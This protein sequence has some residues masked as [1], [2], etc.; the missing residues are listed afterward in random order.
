MDAG[1]ARRLRDFEDE[2]VRF[3]RIIADLSVQK[4][5]L[6]EVH[7]KNGEPV[8]EKVD[9]R[10]ARRERR[11]R[12]GRS[13]LSPSW[14]RLLPA[15]EHP[16]TCALTTGRSS[17]PPLSKT[18]CGKVSVQAMCITA[19]SAWKNGYIESFHNNL[20]DEYLN[21]KFFGGLFEVLVIYGTW[22]IEFNELPLR[23]SLR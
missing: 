13:M 21:C 6:K 7:S 3:K 2:N 17:L 12:S 10:K 15:T 22:R 11:G 1:E 23:A 19:G 20:H 14:K 16:S 9:C 5:I 4:N 8:C 18:G